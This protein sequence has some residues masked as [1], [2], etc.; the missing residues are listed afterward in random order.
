MDNGT[1][2][3]MSFA[4]RGETT[5]AMRR[6]AERERLDPEIGP[7]KVAPPAP[8]QPPSV[9]VEYRFGDSLAL[10]GYNAEPARPAAGDNLTVALH[11]RALAKPAAD[12]AVSV[13]L[14][15]EAGRLVAQHDSPP[16]A[17]DYPASYWAADEEV[18]DRHSLTI[19]EDAPGGVYRLVAVVYT[20]AG[21][22][23]LPVA[24]AGDNAPF[25][26]ISLPPER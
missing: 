13:Q 6:V 18:T 15:D 9:P 25:A 24:G 16:V 21:Q 7:M 11:W 26:Q 10:V 8:S 4:R 5:K 3:Q 1:L 20:V 2:T 22:K 14:L 23:R 12:Y 17:G 19:P